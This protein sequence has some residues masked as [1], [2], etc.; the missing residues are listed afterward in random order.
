MALALLL[1]EFDL[2]F[3][4]KATSG[5]EFIHALTVSDFIIVELNMRKII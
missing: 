1:C 2:S 3:Y 4:N 5:G